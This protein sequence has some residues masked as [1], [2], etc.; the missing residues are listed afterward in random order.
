MNPSLGNKCNLNNIIYQ[1]NI[2]TKK[3]DT[4]EKAYINKTAFSFVSFFLVEILTWYIISL[5]L[6]LFPRGDSFFI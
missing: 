2:S 4:N 5:R 1:V 3:N 6:H